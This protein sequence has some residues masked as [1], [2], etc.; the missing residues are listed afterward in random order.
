VVDKSVPQAA[1]RDVRSEVHVMKELKD[2]TNILPL[3][4]A[5]ETPT[6]LC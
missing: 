3:L 2:H 4:D 1:H 6:H 5:F